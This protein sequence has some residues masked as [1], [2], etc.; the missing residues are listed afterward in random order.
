[1][2]V[3]YINWLGFVKTLPE[4]YMNLAKYQRYSSDGS[5]KI[6]FQQSGLS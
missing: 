5:K 2:G 3:I 6:H 4:F 1:M